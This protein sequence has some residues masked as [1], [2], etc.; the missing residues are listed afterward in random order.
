MRILKYT[1]DIPQLIVD[2]GEL[3]EK[4]S[5]KETHTFTLLFKGINLYEK[6]AGKPLLNELSKYGNANQEIDIEMIKNLACASWCKIE[7]DSFH[8]NMVTAEEFKKTEA[9]NL[10]G[11]DTE[12]MTKLLE[13]VMDCCLSE[14][15]KATM[16][17]AVNPKK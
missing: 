4:G 16:K 13:M 12:F 6:L 11:K 9:F 7:N 15:Q 5:I 14:N 2:D 8:Q 10:I 3:F 1:F 17:G